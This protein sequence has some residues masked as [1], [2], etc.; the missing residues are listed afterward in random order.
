IDWRL[1]STR[2]RLKGV[3]QRARPLG[4]VACR[5]G[6]VS[7]AEAQVSNAFQEL[8]VNLERQHFL[9]LQQLREENIRLVDCNLKLVSWTSG[10]K[11]GVISGNHMARI[12]EASATLSRMTGMDSE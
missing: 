6:I 7:M 3:P 2:H 4:R 8:L 5:H 10:V 12:S 9:E 11:T 1:Q